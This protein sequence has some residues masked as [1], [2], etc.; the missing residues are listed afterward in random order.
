MPAQ[1]TPV[2]RVAL[3]SRQAF[4]ACLIYYRAGHAQPPHEHDKDSF[5]IVLAG[6]LEEEVDRQ[7]HSAGPG[8]TS[9]K[10]RGTV[11]SD[12][13]G[14]QGAVLLSY[15]FRCEETAAEV[16]GRRGW[17]W[18]PAGSSVRGLV[19]GLGQGRHSPG[20]GDLLWEALGAT[21]ARSATGQPP[22]WL[23]WARSE[24]DRRDQP[25][26]IELLAREAGV[27][28]VHFTREFVR[29]FGLPPAA[30]R[31]RQ[32]A[33]RAL[34]ALVEDRLAPAA[35]AHDAGFA[36]Q[37]HMSRSIRSTFGMTPRRI[38]ALLAG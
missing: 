26:G 30:Y 24:L 7:D 31:Q 17:Q 1:P 11:H 34:R 6:S 27:H 16:L 10:P 36:D 19:L 37:S 28:R 33:A 13:Y 3:L 4:D 5:S 18:R 14:P 32:M 23:A 21:E 9:V 25:A 29:H 2:R 22:T 38:A 12:R 20:L 15:V 8:Q 35:A